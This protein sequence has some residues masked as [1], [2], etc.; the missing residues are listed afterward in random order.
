MMYV[1]YGGVLYDS[2]TASSMMCKVL[3]EEVN[4]EG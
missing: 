4:G 2:R 1:E 3:N